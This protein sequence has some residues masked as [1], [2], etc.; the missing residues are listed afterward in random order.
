MSEI[1]VVRVLDHGFVKLRNIAGPT[2]R[3]DAAYDADD[4]DPA[5]AARMS[6]D[7]MDE[8]RAR[9][10]DLRLCRYL[11]KHAHTSP[12]EMVDVWIEM[13]MPI[14]VARQYVRHRTASINEISGRYIKLPAEWYIP[15]VVGGKAANV[16]QGQEDNLPRALQDEFKADLNAA[17][18]SNYA[19]YEHYLNAGVAPEHARMLLHLNT[20]THWLFKQDLHNIMHLLSLREDGHAQVEA[21]AYARAIIQLLRQYLP[22]SMKLYDEFRKQ[23]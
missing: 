7:G 22:E 5:Q 18:S 11:M 14:F 4:V 13:K 19:T 2:R 3:H 16:K 9:E 6:F 17:C 1:D 12:F 10:E 15:E 23:K 8:N 20:Y 21:Q